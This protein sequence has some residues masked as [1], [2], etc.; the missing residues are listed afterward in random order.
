MRPAALVPQV[1][2]N[3][4]AQYC[5]VNRV[6]VLFDSLSSSLVYIAV[7]NTYDN[8]IV[9]TKYGSTLYNIRMDKVLAHY[10]CT[11]ENSNLHFHFQ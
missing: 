1:H 5:F 10:A 3:Y 7:G 4:K 11:F 6:A 8:Y 9:I 2:E